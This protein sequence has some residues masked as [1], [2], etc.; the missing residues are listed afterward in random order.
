MYLFRCIPYKYTTQKSD[1]LLIYNIFAKDLVHC[2]GR[3]LLFSPI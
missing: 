3:H 2:K 1:M